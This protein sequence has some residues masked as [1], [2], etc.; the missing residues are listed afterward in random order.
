MKDILKKFENYL[1]EVS[2]ISPKSL[3]FYRSDVN[4]FKSWLILKVRALGVFAEHFVQLVPFI[5]KSVSQ[6]YKGYLLENNIPLKTINRRLSTLRHLSRFL[7]V[8]QLTNE[9]FMDGESNLKSSSIEDVN[10]SVV[11]NYA[12]FLAD[13]K[14]SHNT[15]KNYISDVKQFLSW[16]NN[17]PSLN[18]NN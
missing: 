7:L 12:S 10:A 9:D 1:L 14:V 16:L 4:H 11:K 6:E 3:K 18:S 8:N 2:G 13:Q 17:K 15:S 5:N